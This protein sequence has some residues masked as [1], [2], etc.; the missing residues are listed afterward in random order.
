MATQA[1]SGIDVR[2]QI[3]GIDRSPKDIPHGVPCS[4]PN[5]VT[6]PALESRPNMARD[7]GHLLVGG[8]CPAL[9]GRRNHM[10]PGAEFR[11]VGQRNGSAAERDH[12][13]HE[14]E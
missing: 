10:A 14:T 2:V 12:A 5:L 8:R 9:I 13:G 7:A 3:M 1:A 6:Q 4:G 11:I